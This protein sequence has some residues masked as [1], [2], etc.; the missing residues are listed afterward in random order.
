MFD[1]LK[2]PL[3]GFLV[4]TAALAGVRTLAYRATVQRI[5]A[6]V[7][8]RVSIGDESPAHPV[9]SFCAYLADPLPQVVLL[10]LL[11]LGARHWG[12]VRQG[13]VAT[14]LV[15]GANLTT[16]VLK[17]IL[18]QPRYQH[19]LGSDQIPATGFPSGHA[20]AS[21][22]M[23]L[24]FVLV[25]PRSLRRMTIIVGALFVVAVGCSLVL[26][27]RH[28]PSD[29][30]GGWLV[31]GAWGCLALTALRVDRLSPAA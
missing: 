12:R 8:H 30:L 22:A 25:V 20:T 18:S 31:A 15:L 3:T 26:L 11:G 6:R 9:A 14:G 13:I 29:I 28:Y 16:Q 17:A 21:M 19:I 23:A 10:V 4:C 1:R 5:D 7:L 24:A 2:W 27:H